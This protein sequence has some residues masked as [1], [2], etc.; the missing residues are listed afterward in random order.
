MAQRNWLSQ[1]LFTGHAMLVQ[2]DC[3]FVVNAS[4]SAGLGITSGSLQG[5]YVQNIFMHTTQTPGVGNS[6]PM[7]PGIA[8]TNPNP[9]AGLIVVQLQD[10]FKKLY[11]VDYDIASPLSGSNL[12]SISA[13]NAYSIV[14]LGTT[15]AAQWKAAGVPSGI[16]PAVG[17]TFIGAETGAIGGTG[18]VQASA[19]GFSGV[20]AI[21]PIMGQSADVGP[22]VTAQGFGGQIILQCINASNSLAAP[23]AGS[24]IHLRMLLSNSSVTLQGD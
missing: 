18:A 22:L 13:G 9:A 8:I 1:K 14:S 23:A 15:T 11:L 24:V 6:N 3:N 19:S 2:V 16:T 4:D 20:M 17:V 21:E 5:P 12:T 7:T 10:S